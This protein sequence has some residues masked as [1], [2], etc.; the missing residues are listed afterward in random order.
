MKL[1]IDEMPASPCDCLFADKCHKNTICKLTECE[2]SRF[3][4]PFRE[5]SLDECECLM[6]L[7]F[8]TKEKFQKI[9]EWLPDYET[10]VD[11]WDRESEPIQTGWVCSVC[12]K[13]EVQ[14]KPYCHCGAKMK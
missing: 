9:G 12:G 11:E 13:Q 5:R 3:N 2:C 10:F 14:K 8:A 7:D 6:T 4:L 1:I